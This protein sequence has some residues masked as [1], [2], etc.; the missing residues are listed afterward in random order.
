MANEENR[1]I[2]SAEFTGDAIKDGVNEVIDSLVQAKEAEK[3]LKEEIKLTNKELKENTERL[4]ANEAALKTATDP[5]LIKKYS[6]NVNALSA[7]EIILT[8]NLRE[9][10]KELVITQKGVQSYNRE[11]SETVK[12][13]QS[14]NKAVG[15]LFNIN[16]IAGEG[17]KKLTGEVKNLA[18]GLVSGFAGG[19]VSMVIPSIVELVSSLF[20]AEKELDKFAKQR[21]V[22]NKVF[23]DGAKGA[24]K[25]T[26]QL[27]V[28]KEKLNDLNVPQAERIKIAKEYNKTAEEG[29]K[30]DVEQINNLGLI[31]D[32]IDKQI[33]LIQKRAIAAAAMNQIAEK[34]NQAIEAELKFRNELKLQGFEDQD[35]IPG[36]G[37]TIAPVGGRALA[38]RN[39]L[40]EAEL[41][42]QKIKD[43]LAL[44]KKVR[45]D[46]KETLE[47]T[48]KLLNPF[49]DTDVIIKGTPTKKIE[50]VFEQ[51]LAELKSKLAAAQEKSFSSEPLIKKKFA[52]QLDKEFKDIE[53]LLKEKKLEGPQADIL[54]GLLTQINDVLLD[55]E[56]NEFRAKRNA[57]LEKI[58]DLIV[59][60]QTELATKRISNIRDDFDREREEIN[61]GFE[62]TR[63]TLQNQLK[64]T[65]K[66]I[67]DLSKLGV[68]ADTIK[69]KKFLAN[70]L[71]AGLLDQAEVAKTNKELDLS[72][73]VFQETV[74]ANNAAFEE[75]LVQNDEITAGQIQSFKEQ[76]EAGAITYKQFQDKVTQSLQD[77]KKARDKIRLAELNED[78]QAINA[79]LQVTTDPKQREQLEAQAR[80]IRSQIASINSSVE[81]NDPNKKRIDNLIAYANAVN[82]L[83]GNI[84]SFWNQVNQT[85]QQALERSIALQER[86]VENAREIADRGNAEYL[87]MEQK[88]LDELE[89]K[90][91]ANAR[92]QL[93][94][95]NALTL[96]Q[97]TVAA[98]T[99]IAQ[100][101]STGSPLAAFAAVGAVTAA[102]LA[103]FSFVNSLQPQVASFYQGEE[104]VEQNGNPSG[105]DTIPARL[106]IGERVVTTEDNKQY[107]NTLTAIHNHLVPP[108]VLNSFVESYPNNPVPVVDFNKLSNAT[109][110]RMGSDSLEVLTKFD[111]L[112]STM[113]EIV[114]AVNQSG[115]SVSIDENGFALNIEKAVRARKI[116][117]KS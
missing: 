54:K 17:V 109:N 97:A 94:I 2:Y 10:N 43:N 76:Y 105:R 62:R 107:W 22:L 110:G 98:I 100:A 61:Q 14:A 4:K 71:F 38:Q 111:Q 7:N 113:K 91:E 45:N 66:Q 53:K 29:N 3:Q 77:A 36:I 52:A 58:S 117:W 86:R 68:D 56:L 69:R 13:N 16:K 67:E 96:S 99:A 63:V 47:E 85:E 78:L 103:A 30:I 101:V 27:V 20:D 55:K 35:I 57:A 74:K 8:K 73:K 41:A 93:A 40:S 108:S 50:N 42:K 64:A 28:F 89:R 115:I 5:A 90:H 102:I 21:E 1:V 112:N 75:L 31:N 104:Y 9:A 59:S 81:K 49:L 15:D 12:A 116:K 46:S 65:I 79:R 60:L 19:L 24:A 83:L 6:D 114:G 106:N 84:V 39:Q 25:E 34:A 88:R 92:K 82:S 87:E 95:N 11:L 72:F 44:L 32:Q 23:E 18:F 51:K 37:V 48:I 80:G 70:I 33:Q 26:A